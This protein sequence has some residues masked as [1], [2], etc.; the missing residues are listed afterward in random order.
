MAQPLPPNNTATTAQP[1]NQDCA[2]INNTLKDVVTNLS[3]IV[4]NI[5][6]SKKRT[7]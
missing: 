1:P 2:N 3:T 4:T 7:L 5:P 6:I